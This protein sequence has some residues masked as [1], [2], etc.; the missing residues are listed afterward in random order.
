[1][2]GSIVGAFIYIFVC[3]ED[4][5]CMYDVDDGHVPFDLINALT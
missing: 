2:R 5:V 3:G 4:R 1:M